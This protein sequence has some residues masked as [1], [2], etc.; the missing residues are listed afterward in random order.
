MGDK[1]KPDFGPTPLATDVKKKQE[2]PTHEPMPV[3]RIGARRAC[4]SFDSSRRRPATKK[5]D[6]PKIDLDLPPLPPPPGVEERRRQ[7]RRCA[8]HLAAHPS[9]AR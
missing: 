2:R 6:T 8:A 5:D 3:I 1:R 7:E 4:C 9:R